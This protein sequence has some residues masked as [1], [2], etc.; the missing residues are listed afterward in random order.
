MLGLLS[1]WSLVANATQ[2]TVSPTR[3]DRTVS[4]GSVS[5]QT[6]TL[7][8]QSQGP[9]RIEC[10]ALPMGVADHVRVIEVVP[11]S[12]PSAVEWISFS[13]PA[14]VLEP[15]E[16]RSVD[17]SVAAPE[18]ASG[19][20]YAALA[21]VASPGRDAGD[22]FRSRMVLSAT[23]KVDGANGGSLEV[24]D[25]KIQAPTST[26]PFSLELDVA[27][28]G[29]IYSVASL[30]GIVRPVGR[31]RPVAR[32]QLKPRYLLPGEHGELQFS[33]GARFE[34]GSYE[35]VGALVDANG[36]AQTLQVPFT[37]E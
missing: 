23:V 36:S 30:T 14:M 13:P 21:F 2:I 7:V 6:F 35:V 22:T 5:V 9:V 24:L 18:Q 37:V 28:A 33:S 29:S 34:P 26:R 4:A 20:A 8:N 1:L 16:V 11:E 25:Q 19:A 12:T 3:L 17:V 10:S 15:G 32:I 31:N 27:A